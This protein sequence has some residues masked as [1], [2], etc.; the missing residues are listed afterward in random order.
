MGKTDKNVYFLLIA[1]CDV[2]AEAL[3]K[4]RKKAISL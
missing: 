3:K 2:I 1:K 4:K